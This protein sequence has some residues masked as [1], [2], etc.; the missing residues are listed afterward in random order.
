MD[1]IKN[2]FLFSWPDIETKSDLDRLRLVLEHLP[3]EELMLKLEKQSGGS[4]RLPDTSCLELNPGRGSLSAQEHRISPPRADAQRRTESTLW[5]Q[6][7][8]V[9]TPCRLLGYIRG[10]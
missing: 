7:S 4:Q 8:W 3:D 2:P 6:P 5:I 10:F 1:K 9:P